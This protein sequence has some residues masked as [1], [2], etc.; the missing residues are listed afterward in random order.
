MRDV[1]SL[2]RR[3][4]TSCVLGYQKHTNGR[5]KTVS[6]PVP[7]WFGKYAVVCTRVDLGIASHDLQRLSPSLD[8]RRRVSPVYV[9]LYTI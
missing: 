5:L 9:L 7:S 3:E 8:S 1:Q 2:I 6:V 4:V